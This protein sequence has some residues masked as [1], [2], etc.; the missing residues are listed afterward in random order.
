MHV[1]GSCNAKAGGILA[2]GQSSYCCDLKTILLL[3]TL[4][5][6]VNLRNLAPS[7]KPVRTGPAPLAYETAHCQ[8]L[9][10]FAGRVPAVRLILLCYC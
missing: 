5:T 9:V 1:K 3:V 8:A 2:R 7:R 10:V 4:L 6:D